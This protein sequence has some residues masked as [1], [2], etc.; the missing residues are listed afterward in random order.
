MTTDDRRL[1]SRIKFDTEI[2]IAIN[3]NTIT[4]NLIDI[5]L[6][7]AL[8]ESSSDV[9]LSK[10]D[11]GILTISLGNSTIVLSINVTLAYQKDRDLGFRFAEM[12]LDTV[13]HLRRLI[14]LNVG[15]SEK[16][17]E[18]LFFLVQAP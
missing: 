18:E 15:D 10:D 6:Q 14:E 2:S 1:F 3:K 8:I 12:E 13:M 16:V 11:K 4:G 9:S 7:G 17:R 5:S